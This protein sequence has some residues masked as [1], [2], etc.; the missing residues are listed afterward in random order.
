MK[1]S[2]LRW[3]LD[4]LTSLFALYLRARERGLMSYDVAWRLARVIRRPD[5]LVYRSHGHLPE[6]PEDTAS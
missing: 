5:E 6:N 3:L 2:V 1:T 4:P